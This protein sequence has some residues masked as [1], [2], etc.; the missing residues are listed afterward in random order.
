MI[1]VCI[2]TSEPALQIYS[3]NL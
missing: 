1:A 2:I 3:L